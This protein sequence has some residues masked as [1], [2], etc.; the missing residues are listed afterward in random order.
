MEHLATDQEA[1]QERQAEFMNQFLPVD[2]LTTSASGLSPDIRRAYAVLPVAYVAVARGH[3]VAEVGALVA[4]FVVFSESYEW[5][6]HE[7][8]F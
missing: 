6:N 4:A 8:S 1:L 5:E 3:P 7:R 2:M